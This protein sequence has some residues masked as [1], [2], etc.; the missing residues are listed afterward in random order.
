MTVLEREGLVSAWHDRE[1]PPGTDWAEEVSDR[2]ES[3]DIVLLLLSADFLASDYCYSIEMNRALERQAEGKTAVVPVILRPVHWQE[4][5]LAA[6]TPLPAAGKAV[7]S[8]DDRD[9]AFAEVVKGIRQIAHRIHAERANAANRHAEPTVSRIDLV[10]IVVACPT[11]AAKYRVNVWNAGRRYRCRSCKC[12]EAV[13]HELMLFGMAAGRGSVP[14]D[15]LGQVLEAGFPITATLLLT[16]EVSESPGCVELDESDFVSQWRPDGEADLTN[17]LHLFRHAGNIRE[18]E[19]MLA[20]AVR[21]RH[22]P[23]RADLR[24]AARALLDLAA[25]DEHGS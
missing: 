14:E 1:I 15:V 5:V 16:T 25:K 19:A 22:V 20:T 21:C 24:Q 4:G 3:A 17:A 23:V 9:A 18:I 7:V 13:P 11:C 2:L 8:W 12:E 6:L 10:P